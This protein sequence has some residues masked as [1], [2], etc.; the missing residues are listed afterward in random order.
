[1]GG[2]FTWNGDGMAGLS[3]YLDIYGYVVPVV[4]IAIL[5]YK[6][7]RTQRFPDESPVTHSP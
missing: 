1:M 5:F 4:G 7:R 3:V 2:L 6:F